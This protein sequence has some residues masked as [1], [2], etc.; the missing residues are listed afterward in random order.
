MIQINKCEFCA[1][2]VD[3][4]CLAFKE[5]LESCTCYTESCQE[6]ISEYWDMITYIE[7]KGQKATD[8]K[9]EL[10]R[11]LKWCGIKKEA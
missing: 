11:Y 6:V 7:G 1:R 9:L 4:K 3:K 2:N 5:Q 10:N 8:I